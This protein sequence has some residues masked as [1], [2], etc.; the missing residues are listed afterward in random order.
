MTDFSNVEMSRGVSS[1]GWGRR[2][3]GGEGERKVKRLE[4]GVEG[5]RRV[6]RGGEKGVERV[7]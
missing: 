5:W 7:G 3:G 6:E 1:D 4:E 2:R